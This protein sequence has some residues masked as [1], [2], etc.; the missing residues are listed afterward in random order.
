MHVIGH[1][2]R[3]RTGNLERIIQELNGHGV[4]PVI[5]NNSGLPIGIGSGHYT[6]VDSPNNPIHGRYLTALIYPES[7]IFIFQDDDLIL[8]PNTIHLLTEAARSD[9]TRFYGI[10]GR[11]LKWGSKTP[12]SLAVPDRDPG[13]TDMCIRAY[14]CHRSA[15]RFGLNWILHNGIH[16]GRSETI[17]FTGGRSRLVAGT[18]F[19]NLPENGV[20]LSYA[21]DH[22]TEID[23]FVNQWMR[24]HFMPALQ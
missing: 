11:R 3:N 18:A 10:E 14:A 5:W 21:G 16:P 22:D 12:Y 24:E 20:G 7:D 17:L 19:Q 23:A 9:H 15:L 13:K 6:V 4:H 2:Y 1:Y 8:S